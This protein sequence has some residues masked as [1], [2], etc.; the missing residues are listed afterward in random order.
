MEWLLQLD[1]PHLQKLACAL[2]ALLSTFSNSNV[3]DLNLEVLDSYTL[4]K[5]YKTV[6]V[7][8]L[9]CKVAAYLERQ[10]VLQ[11]LFIHRQDLGIAISLNQI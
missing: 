11:L 7:R 3:Q 8:R 9:I 10:C 2:F 5:V 4:P 6:W 1:E